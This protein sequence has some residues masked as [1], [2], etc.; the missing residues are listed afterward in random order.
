[1]QKFDRRQLQC[2][3]LSVTN[4]MCQE[5]ETAYASRFS[6]RHIQEF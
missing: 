3:C 4:W 5:K 1:M 2:E 6:S